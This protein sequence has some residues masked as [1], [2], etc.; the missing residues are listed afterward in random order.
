MIKLAPGI[1]TSINKEVNYK[2]RGMNFENEINLSNQYYLNND[3][4][5]IYKKPTPIKIIKTKSYNNSYKIE[6]AIFLA[7]STTDYNGIYKGRYIDFEAKE[8]NSITSF[9]LSNIHYNQLI[10]LERIINHGGI[11]FLLIRFNRLNLNYLVDF[12]IVKCME[13][14]GRKSIS[15][16]TIKKDG[17]LIPSKYNCPI[18]YIKIVDKIYF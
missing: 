1:N 13:K 9:P 17:F 6:E 11:G 4:A 3:I 14:L 7:P 16:E 10:H 18:D 12:K 5:I 8:T 2:N 15:I